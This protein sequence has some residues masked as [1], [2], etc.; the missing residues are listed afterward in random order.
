M[1][2]FGLALYIPGG[3]YMYNNSFKGQPMSEW[4]YGRTINSYLVT[5]VVFP[6]FH[7]IFDV[8]IDNVFG[9]EH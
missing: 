4:K 5:W 2:V 3:L 1:I 6:P 8:R 7:T 9:K